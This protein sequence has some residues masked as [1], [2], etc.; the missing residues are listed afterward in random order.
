MFEGN[1]MKILVPDQNYNHLLETKECKI[2]N[3]I[4]IFPIMNYS[5]HNRFY[6]CMQ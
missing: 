1:R 6:F 4:R 3:S 2:L 5:K